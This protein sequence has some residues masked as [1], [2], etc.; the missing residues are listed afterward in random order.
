MFLIE[1]GSELTT[2]RIRV[3]ILSF[4]FYSV[5]LKIYKKKIHIH[6]HNA[7]IIIVL[8]YLSSIKCI[9]I[10]ITLFEKSVLCYFID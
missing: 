9:L 5:W 8:H 7:I 1:P 3:L 10:L 2:S 4:S 6:A